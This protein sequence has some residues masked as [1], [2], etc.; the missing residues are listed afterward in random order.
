MVALNSG[1]QAVP[2]PLPPRIQN[3]HELNLLPVIHR[4][5]RVQARQSFTYWGRV[6]AMAAMLA[7]ACYFA[8]TR[9]LSPQEGGELFVWL[10]RLLLLLVWILVPI[11]TADAISRERRE[12]TL[13]LLFLTPLKAWDIVIAKA[14]AHALRAFS[15]AV[16]VLPVMAVP[17]LAGGVS[18]IEATLSAFLMLSSLVWAIS[19]GILA[20]SASKQWVRALMWSILIAFVFFVG[21]LWLY[22]A[23]DPFS[24]SAGLPG[25][26]WSSSHSTIM[27]FL[28]AI[29][30]A[31]NWDDF[32]AQATIQWAG[33]RAHLEWFYVAGRTT[34]ISLLLLFAVLWLAA[35]NVRRCWQEKPASALQRWAEAKFCTPV[36]WRGFFR[37]WMRWKLERNPIGW[38][39][40]RTWSARLVTWSWLAVLISI[41]TVALG[42]VNF[43]QHYFDGVHSMLTVMLLASIAAT[44]AG[45]FRRERDSGVLQL[46][47]VAP[48]SVNQLIWGRLRGLWSQ[49]LPTTILLFGA[50]LYLSQAFLPW[51]FYDSYEWQNRLHSVFFCISSYATL[52]VIGLYFSLR[53]RHFLSSLLWTVAISVL[54]PI[55][56]AGAFYRFIQWLG[57]PTLFISVMH[58]SSYFMVATAFQ[59]IAAT[60][61]GR[62]L[63]INLERRSFVLV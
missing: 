24:F 51:T 57:D 13:G 6:I 61:V 16:A 12:G 19:A 3:D 50:W 38:L 36:I 43:Y 63:Q 10:H 39:E 56:L 27:M 32:W 31:I 25:S 21:F 18:W 55:V 29:A 26:G 28:T 49:F 48:L 62:L 2:A 30:Y 53:T 9:G 4:E 60:F 23:T 33:S 34:L 15:M 54:L 42:D 41:Y 8:G 5:I 1:G 59:V 45:S 22:L 11:M 7:V 17:F 58:R 52:P 14:V 40:Q 37:K 46:L 44:A 20:S 35:R 47:L